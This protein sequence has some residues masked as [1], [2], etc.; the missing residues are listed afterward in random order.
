MWAHTFVIVV[1]CF[2]GEI[3]L[4]MVFIHVQALAMRS[5]IEMPLF[6]AAYG[7]PCSGISF[8]Y[9]AAQLTPLASISAMSIYG[10]PY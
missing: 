5:F 9:P 7:P 2:Q 1:M 8:I 4:Q 10:S 6:I 3:R